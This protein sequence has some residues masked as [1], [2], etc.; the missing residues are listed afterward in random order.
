[1]TLE[2]ANVPGVKR[3]LVGTF[4]GVSEQD[5]QRYVTK[6]DFRW[7]YRIKIGCNAVQR[8]QK[9]LVN[10]VRKRLKHRRIAAYG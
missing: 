10:I 8:A 4:H 3:G 1:M 7:G 2:K 6:L 9:L 5:L